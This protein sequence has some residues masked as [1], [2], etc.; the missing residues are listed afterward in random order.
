[1]SRV[2]TKR[3]GEGVAHSLT[4]LMAPTTNPNAAHTSTTA[5]TTSTTTAAAAD[6]L[7][8]STFSPRPILWCL[9]LAKL[10]AWL[11]ACLRTKSSLTLQSLYIY[12]APT[13]LPSL[14]PT[15]PPLL[16]RL[17]TPILIETRTLFAGKS[18]VGIS[19]RWGC[20]K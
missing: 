1:M 16:R 3:R 5:S 18:G 7:P 17:P 11:A 4:T 20:C 8:S 13:T 9:L 14:P 12:G 10:P 15:P 19:T 6:L 2:E